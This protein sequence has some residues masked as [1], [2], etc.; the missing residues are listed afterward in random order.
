[1]NERMRKLLAAKQANINAA[2]AISATADDEGLLV[3]DDQK[4]YDGLVAKIK[5]QNAAIATEQSL[6]DAAMNLGGDHIIGEFDGGG[7]DS[8]VKVGDTRIDP[9]GGFASMGDFAGAVIMASADVPVIDP[10]LVAMQA[11]APTTLTRESPA[12]DGGFLVPPQMSQEIFKL[13]LG[14]DSFIPL[15]SNQETEGNSMTYRNNG[16]VTPWGSS[17]IQAY[18]T[19]EGAAISPSDIS[20]KTDTMKLHK[21]AALVPV[22]E[23]MMQDY[24]A[25]TSYLTDE[26]SDAMRWVANE[27]IADGNG[28]GK[29]DGIFGSDAVVTVA[30]ETSQTAGTVNAINIAK[31]FARWHARTAGQRVI[32]NP[33]VFSQIILM[34]LGDQP[35]WTP[36]VS[37][38]K[39]NPDGFLLGR[40]IIKT[41]HCETLGALNDILMVDFGFYRTLNKVGGGIRTDVSMH[42]YFDSDNLAFRF[43]FRLAG[44]SKMSAAITPPKSA[45]T[46]SPF[47]NLAAR[48]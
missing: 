23:E 34:T 5:Q 4:K 11:A 41:D 17:G 22:T 25:L 19:E 3:E 29:P 18:W 45:V 30:K 7:E 36:P 46:R 16:E 47:V 24:A 37:G 9:T 6:M 8:L 15:T 42:L 43:T 28:V 32:M 38:F 35:I 31:M 12:S 39:E 27:A 48:S 13:M 33:D 26:G 10:R 40:P 20:P 44:Q 2:E 1:M 21:L 14:E